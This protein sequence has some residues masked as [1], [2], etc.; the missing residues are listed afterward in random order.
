MKSG[1]G[2]PVRLPNDKKRRKKKPGW[3][4]RRSEAK[5]STPPSSHRVPRQV[6]RLQPRIQANQSMKPIIHLDQ[7][8]QIN[9]SPPIP[10]LAYVM[11][12][13]SNANVMK[14]KFAV[15]TR[16]RDLLSNRQHKPDPLPIPSLPPRALRL[17]PMR[18][19]VQLTDLCLVLLLDAPHI[20]ARF[21][22][23]PR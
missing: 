21:S 1:D 15:A 22:P 4:N 7:L 11:C 12:N 2:K 13:Q 18:I 14:L 16:S 9:P 19:K 10:I 6:E 20:R 23:R 17:L 3:K 5:P 8:M